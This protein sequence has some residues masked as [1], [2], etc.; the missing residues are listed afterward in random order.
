MVLATAV[1]WSWSGMVS[2]SRLWS[3]RGSSAVWFGEV[4]IRVVWSGMGWL[5]ESGLGCKVCKVS[6]S[7]FGSD[8]V[9]SSAIWL[10]WVWFRVVWSGKD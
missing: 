7:R 10:D 2:S 3:V 4:W 8:R 5:G 6:S 9:G 1:V